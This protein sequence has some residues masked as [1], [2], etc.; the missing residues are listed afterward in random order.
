[1]A[2]QSSMVHD[3]ETFFQMPGKTADTDFMHSKHYLKNLN[4]HA[5]WYSIFRISYLSRT[6]IYAYIVYAH[7]V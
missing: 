7:I 1:L 6:H 3:S 5:Y 4:S 2:E